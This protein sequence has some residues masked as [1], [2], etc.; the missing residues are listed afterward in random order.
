VTILLKKPKTSNDEPLQDI[1]CIALVGRDTTVGRQFRPRDEV[2]FGTSHG[3]ASI[4]T[5][6]SAAVPMRRL[7]QPTVNAPEQLL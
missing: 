3:S 7:Q 5:Q 1:L 4:Q 2:T 6:K